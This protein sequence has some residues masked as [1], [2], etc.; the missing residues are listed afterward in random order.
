MSQV[1][2]LAHTITSVPAE[3]PF[4]KSGLMRPRAIRGRD[5]AKG[6]DET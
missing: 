1:C 5:V 3:R 6:L 2:N 4:E